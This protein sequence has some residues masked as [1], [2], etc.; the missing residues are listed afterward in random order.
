VINKVR[1]RSSNSGGTAPKTF[2]IRGSTDNF[3]SSNDLLYSGDEAS[4]AINTWKEFEFEND[5]SYDYMRVLVTE[6][7]GGTGYYVS[8]SEIEMMECL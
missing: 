3:S 4:W 8:L 7:Q 2:E 1:I 5:T 6:T